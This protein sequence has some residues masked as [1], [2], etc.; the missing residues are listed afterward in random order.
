LAI[1]RK[2][3]A[4]PGALLGMVSL[5]VRLSLASVDDESYRA[6]IDRAYQSVL[7]VHAGL[8]EPQAAPRGSESRRMPS[9]ITAEPALGKNRYLPVGGPPPGQREHAD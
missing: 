1:R 7:R 5:I 9:V 8:P 6:G 4:V 2:P 3:D